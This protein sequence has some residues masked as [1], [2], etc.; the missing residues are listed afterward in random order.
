MDQGCERIEGGGWKQRRKGKAVG[1][2]T[3]GFNTDVVVY[4]VCIGRRKLSAGSE[5]G[6]L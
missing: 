4:S 5:G 2:W 6:E 1:M 3:T